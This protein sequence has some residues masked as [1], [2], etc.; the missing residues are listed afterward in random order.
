LGANPI[1]SR[2]V[3]L[4]NMK[5]FWEQEFTEKQFEK[6][7]VNQCKNLKS[8]QVIALIMAGANLTSKL[9]NSTPHKYVC[10]EPRNKTIKS[11]NVNY[12]KN[13]YDASERFDITHICIASS[14]SK[15]INNIAKKVNEIEKLKPVPIIYKVLG[16]KTYPIYTK[17]DQI[18]NNG[19]THDHV[20]ITSDFDDGI[21]EN[22]YS[23]SITKV[24]QKC[25]ARDAHDLYQ[26]LKNI[27]NI[28]GDIIEFGSY[29]GHSGLIMSEYVK[30]FKLNKKIYLCDTFDGFPK[31]SAG[32][33]FIWNGTHNNGYSNVNNLFKDYDFV[34][35][36]KGDFTE[37]AYDIPSNKFCFVMIDCDSYRGTKFALD[38]VWDKISQHGV[39]ACEDYGHHA[40]L[41]AR[42]AIDEFV[43]KH[44]GEMFSF[45]S[46][47][48]G[49]KI[50]VKK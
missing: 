8:P 33:D 13:I 30:T 34:N 4:T 6:Y 20:F 42:L 49:F 36:I 17:Y 16:S 27:N 11:Q 12:C 31:E 48:S 19:V 35:L 28:A 50:L 10:I 18:R 9:I 23:Y 41:G 40:L 25:Q 29:Q 22:I 26:C 47:F 45:F 21:F 14:L 24:P 32:V 15:D 43:D 37:T 2:I 38:F 46:F 3:G 44:M 5:N 1:N 7:L 39:I